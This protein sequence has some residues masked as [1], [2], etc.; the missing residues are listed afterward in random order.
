MSEKKQVM[1]RL[2]EETIEK[3]KA[4]AE[5][6]KRSVNNLLEVIVEKYLKDQNAI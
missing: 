4:Q 1:L 5:K 2:P 6:E 3:L